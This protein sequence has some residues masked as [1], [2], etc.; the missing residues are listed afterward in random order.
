MEL[1]KTHLVLPNFACLDL[2][3]ERLSLVL[4]AIQVRYGMV[5]FLQVRTGNDLL[6]KKTQ[7]KKKKA[8][9]Y[10]QETGP[11]GL[12]SSC[13]CSQEKRWTECVLKP[14]LLTQV[15]TGEKMNE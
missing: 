10:D 9:L 13:S 1:P 4:R 5:F 12:K 6:E 8:F 11:P 2:P 7:E 3:A 14:A 15:E